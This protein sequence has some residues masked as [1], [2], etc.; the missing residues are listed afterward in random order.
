MAGLKTPHMHV[1]QCIWKRFCGG[2]PGG[3]ELLDKERPQET[4]EAEPL[5]YNLPLEAS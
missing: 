3:Q 2:L 5:G 1:K 4:E